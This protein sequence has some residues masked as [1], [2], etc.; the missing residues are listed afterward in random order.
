MPLLKENNPYCDIFASTYRYL[1]R[2]RAVIP[3]IFL[4]VSVLMVISSG[5]THDPL[6]CDPEAIYFERDILPILNSNCALSGCH[7]NITHKEGINFSSYDA[8]M[9]SDEVIDPESP[10]DSDLLEVI[11]ASPQDNDRM[12]PAPSQPLSQEQKSKIEMWLSLGAK[13]EKCNF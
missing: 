10:L 12:P 11:T 4:T 2:S 9:A 8:M 1:M 3:L 5:C 6:E 7:D 13:N